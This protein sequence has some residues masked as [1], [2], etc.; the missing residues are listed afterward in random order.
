MILAGDIGG[1]K[2]NL[3]VFEVERGA[4]ALRAEQKYSSREHSNLEEI[5]RLF[6]GKHKF[7]H[8][9]ACFGI[10]GPVKN[11]RS[12]LTNLRWT[13]DAQAVAKEFA[14]EK[15][16]LLNDLQA[17]AHGI[18]ALPP[19]D[20]FILNK[21]EAVSDGNQCIIAAGTGLGEAGIIWNGNRRIAIASEGGNCDFAPRTE[22]DME[23]LRHLQKQFGE[24]LWEHV[25]SGQGQ[26]N[27]YNFLRD[28]KR[29]EEPA[30][31]AEEFRKGELPP[32]AVITKNALAKKSPLCEAALDLFATY[33]GAEAMSLALKFLATGG[34][35]VGGGIAPKII[36]KLKDGS[37]MKGFLGQHRYHDLLVAMPVKVILNEKTALLG[38]AR[39]AAME[40]GLIS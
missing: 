28:T 39:F 32:P 17:N 37:F 12:L 18:A 40:A 26:V 25:L 22:L 30:W 27:I 3:A 11:G 34:V 4:L 38:A 8:T 1:T 15:V 33:Y 21:G 14:L 13:I 5:I 2:C 23:L 9:H 20:F 29:G 16:S 7:E 10:A 6:L 35:F 31:L 36:E 19:E 24:V